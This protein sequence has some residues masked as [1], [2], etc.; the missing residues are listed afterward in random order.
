MNHVR[1]LTEKD[2]GVISDNNIDERSAIDEMIYCELFI[3]L[4]YLNYDP[5]KI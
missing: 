4:G 1:K 5:T 2:Y 3:C